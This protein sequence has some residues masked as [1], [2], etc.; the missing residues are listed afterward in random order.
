M[1]RRNTGRTRAYTSMQSARGSA[2]EAWQH[3][4]RPIEPTLN[5]GAPMTSP[6]TR[7]AFCAR[8]AGGSVLLLIQAC[9]G[10]GSDDADNP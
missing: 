2:R 3:C 5:L 8:L 6:I 7:K 4:L 9:G 10:G 1:A